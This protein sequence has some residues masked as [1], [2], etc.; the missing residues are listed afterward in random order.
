MARPKT[1]PD[2]HFRLSTFRKGD[3][4][5]IYGYRNEWNPEKKQSRVAKRIYVGTLNEVTG[6]AR[7]GKKYLASHPEYEGKTL[8]YENHELVERNDISEDEETSMREQTHLSNNL[9][10]GAPWALWQ[11]AM[12]NGIFQHLQDAFGK[13]DGR[14]LLALGIYQLLTGQAMSSYEDWVTQ[15]WLPISQPLCSQRISELLSRVEHEAMMKYFHLR[16]NRS[17]DNYKKFTEQQFKAR[18][19]SLPSKPSKLYMAID[20][21]GISTFSVTIE[22]AAFG[23]AKQNPELKQV[24]FTLGVDFLSGDVCYARED[25]GSITDKSVYKSILME[26][27]NYGFDLSETVLVTDRGYSS[28]YNLQSL[29]NCDVSFVAGVPMVEKGVREKFEKYQAALSHIA[30]YNSEH[31]VYC[32]TLTERFNRNSAAGSCSLESYLH[33]YRFPKI[34][35]EQT[36]MLLKKIDKLIKD[37]N[38][39]KK[40][41]PTDWKGICKYVREDSRNHWTKDIEALSRWQNT[42]GCFVIRSD[43]LEEPIEALTLYRRRNIVEV[44]FRQFKVLNGGARL[45][46]TETTYVGKLMVHVIAQS[47]RMA[48]MVQAKARESKELRIPDNSLE[49]MLNSL[50]R[51]RAV[52]APTRVCWV[53]EPIS[54]KARDVLELLG[55]PNPPPTFKSI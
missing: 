36:A 31:D 40:V 8:Y 19:E 6:K 17:K 11:F 53:A 43:Y 16:F 55:L 13:E 46:A 51:I 25:D 44:A 50:K 54:K 9:C 37:K 20:S 45:F 35:A 42:A 22:N 15:A 41:D 47:L 26:M 12:K 49:K 48:L 4:T 18:K 23:H 29:I 30:F 3:H 5:Y 14:N 32:R 39:G 52:R 7:L 10:Y 24:N 21:T 27:Q 33:L 34:A 38:N 2:N 28:L 1:L